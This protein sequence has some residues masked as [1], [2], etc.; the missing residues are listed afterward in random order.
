M[1]KT[2]TSLLLDLA[3]KLEK[4]NSTKELIIKSLTSAGIVTKKGDITKSFPNLERIL[5]I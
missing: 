5:S 1:N 2:Q 4:E 3:K